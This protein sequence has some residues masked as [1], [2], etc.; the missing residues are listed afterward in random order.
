MQ[1]RAL[2]P[3]EI[4]GR[5]SCVTADRSEVLETI[6]HVEDSARDWTERG[7]GGPAPDIGLGV[8]SSP[9]IAFSMVLPTLLRELNA[10]VEAIV[11]SDQLLIFAGYSERVIDEAAAAGFRENPGGHRGAFQ[12]TILWAEEANRLQQSAFTSIPTTIVTLDDTRMYEAEVALDYPHRAMTSWP[13][14]KAVT[15]DGIRYDVLS[16]FDTEELYMGLGVEGE[17]KAV[18]KILAHI[19]SWLGDEWL[20][21]KSEVRPLPS[22]PAGLVKRPRIPPLA[23]AMPV[24]LQLGFY[25]ELRTAL[26]FGT[27]SCS[28]SHMGNFHRLLATQKN[29]VSG[30]LRELA[31][32]RYG[33]QLMEKLER[34]G[35]MSLDLRLPPILRMCLFE[36]TSVEDVLAKAN[37]LRKERRF[38]NLRGYIGDLS[39][40]TNPLKL[41][42]KLERLQRWIEMDI[43]GLGANLVN[44]NLTVGGAATV[45]LSLVTL[46]QQVLAWR[47]PVVM[48]NSRLTSMLAGKDSVMDLARVFRVDRLAAAQAIAAFE[49]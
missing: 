48:V 26:H 31:G 10:L 37:Q 30:Q 49:E 1:N 21:Y 25:G 36:S 28:P 33:A 44:S 9:T 13:V 27:L 22:W 3:V 20:M 38:K 47:N 42:R 39:G 32:R 12:P 29:V 34:H 14:V 45:S 2:V 41:L 16:S 4:F 7:I 11:L 46:A 8:S 17:K 40:E 6:K 23:A 5:L 24:Q 43:R 18:S 35:I 15:D 19:D